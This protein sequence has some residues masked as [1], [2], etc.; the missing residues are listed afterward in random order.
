MSSKNRRDF[1]RLAAQSAGAMAAYAGFPP[2]IRKALAMPA[3]TRTGTIQD[4]EHVVIFMQENRSFDHYFG[5]LR[6]VRGFDDPRPHV[7][8]NGAPVWQQPPASVFTKNYHS[9]GL[10]PS[11]KYVLPFYLDPKQTTEYQPGTNHGWSSG[12]LAWNNGFYDQWVN[13]KQD[14]LTMGYL[15]RDDLTY[16]YALADAFTICDSYFCSTP[17]DTAPNRIF[18]FTGTIDPRNIYGNPP[19]GPG[20]GERDNVNGYTWTTYAER[21]QNANISWKV[22]QG[23]TGIPGDATDNF[24]DNSLMFFKKF[25]VQ[26][27]AS[28]P[29]VDKGA[30]NHTLA[31][32]KADV[33][34]NQLP[35]VS[36][37]VAPA[38]YSEH[39]SSSPTD[40]AFYINMVIEAL[41][42]NPD[43]WAKTVLILNY[44]ENDGLFDH[45]VPPMPPLSSGQ[46]A[47]GMISSSLMSNIGD[48]YLDLGQY[49]HEMGPMIPGADPGGIQ[50]IGLGT[51]VP[52]IVVSPWSK[53]GWVCSEMFDHTSVLRFLE[54]RFGVHEPNISAWRRSLCGDLTS[55]FDFS[56]QPD[57]STVSFTV[58]QHIQTA[59]QAYQVPAQQTM[60]AQ[61]PGTR[62]ARA[63]PYE[64]F[65]QSRVSG[66]DGNLWLDLANTGGAGA[67]FYVYDRLQTANPPRRY[68]VASQDTLTDY[69][70]TSSS[71]GAYHFA[72]YGPNGYL[73][74]FQGNVQTATDGHHANPD[75]RIGYDVQNRQVYLELR[76]TGAAACSITVGNAYSNAHARQYTLQPGQTQ[77]DHWELSSSHGWYDLNIAA[78]T[79]GGA[80]DTVVRRFAGH[81]ETGRPSQSDPGPVK[82]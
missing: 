36:W 58:P 56:G 8:P 73:S 11:A 44:D 53:G 34:A 68:S 40:G 82:G 54:A 27:G 48:E 63:L 25:Q 9:R 20:I 66:H 7:L 22:Y 69:W 75:V 78:T 79:V 49:P 59:G 1:L 19:N 32:L 15:K 24:T 35:Q 74:E 67:A 39:P 38:K 12:H 6:G 18:L 29:L 55:A 43:V 10:D 21:L 70:S 45:V 80:T 65:V 46:N 31:E 64:V 50:P 81:V 77:Q 60:P 26:E 2:A 71:Q 52:L 14:V 57:T 13:Q 61:E 42:S 30:S 37:I 47:Q 5:G 16:H 72:V 62:P 51:R 4:V 3:A 28:G 41:T 23:G 33:Q 17:A 76:N